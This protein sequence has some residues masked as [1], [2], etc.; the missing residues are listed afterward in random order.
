MHTSVRV[1][2]LA[3]AAALTLGGCSL[4]NAVSM[5]PRLNAS[6]SPSGRANV[7]LVNT[8]A[9]SAPSASTVPPSVSAAP[10]ASV[11]GA[12]PAVSSSP[13]ATTRRTPGA[14]DAGS[15]THKLTAGAYTLVI[16]YWTTQSAETWTSSTPATVQLS[17]HIEGQ[18]AS[19][20][21]PKIEVTRFAA[22]LNNGSSL[23]ALTSDDG[24]FVITPPFSY[25]SALLLPGTGPA[26]S[27]A[28]VIVQFNLLIETTPTSGQYFRQT[29]IDTLHL[30]FV[31]EETT[32]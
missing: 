28:D 8:T 30:S 20:R 7:A 17:A 15:V 24:E 6:P 16:D 5:S 26:T 22:M 23:T 25:G 3:T 14:L 19:T 18:A 11:T 12:S 29:V 2:A 21:R 31:P 10:A 27:G 13:S 9:T 4:A 1:A 32:K